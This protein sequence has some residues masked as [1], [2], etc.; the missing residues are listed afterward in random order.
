MSLTPSLIVCYLVIQAIQAVPISEAESHVVIVSRVQPDN[1]GDIHQCRTIWNIIWS[2]LATL[3]ACTWL[4]LHL[5]IPA[6]DDG[7]FKIALRKV[8]TMI[9]VVLAPEFV[10]LWAVRQFFSARRIAKRVFGFY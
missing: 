2:C 9:L 8:G 1:C 4:A 7:W 5:N 3:F 6:P 10:V